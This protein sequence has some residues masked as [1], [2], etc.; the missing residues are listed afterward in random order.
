[1]TPQAS[2]L[3]ATSRRLVVKIGSSILVDETKG[4]VRRD[5]LEALTNDVARLHKGGC[6]P[7]GNPQH[8]PNPETVLFEAR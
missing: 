7:D 5:W 2:S 3:L 6:G 4:E 8:Q 1:M